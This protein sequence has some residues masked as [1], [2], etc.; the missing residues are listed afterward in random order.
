MASRSFPAI[1]PFLRPSRCRIAF[2]SSTRCMATTVAT[3]K[4]PQ[5]DSVLPP[6]SAK[7]KG[8]IAEPQINGIVDQ[9]SG[10]TLLQ[11]AALV[12]ALKTRLNIQEIAAPV[13]APVAA[14][15]VD[16]EEAPVE[17]K[18][19]EKTIF[20]VKLESFEATAKPKIIREVK[21]LIPNLNLIDAKKFVESVP[22]TV[23]ENMPKEDAE[24]L[25]ATLEGL[26]AKVT[27]E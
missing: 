2:A 15:P 10:L 26:G 4:P 5:G 21:A 23:K 20:S 14:A 22:K 9:I 25:K 1:R 7:G 3:D 13:A 8:P 19:K 12:A 27:L 6:P 16:T 24:K 18:P 11:A 17:E